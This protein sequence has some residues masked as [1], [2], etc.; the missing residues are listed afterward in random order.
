M[1]EK[2]EGGNNASTENA[3]AKNS[4]GTAKGK[5]SNNEAMKQKAEETN[6]ASKE[7]EEYDLK[8]RLL[9]LAAE[10]DNYKKHAR[11]DIDS[12]KKIG[13]A[14]LVK[15]LLPVLDEFELAIIALNNSTSMQ[16]KDQK[17]STDVSKGIEM[18]YSNFVDALKKNGIHEVSTQGAFDP[19]KHE[20]IMVKESEK[21]DNVII[22]VVKKGYEL[23][24][25]LIRPA[26]VIV[27]KKSDMKK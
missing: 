22:E 10:F 11:S 7:S 25:I 2:E 14:E 16:N 5:D 19:Y 15:S 17:N 23:D 6:R 24:S 20:I 13:K 27:S 18:V 26:S 3:Q 4:E 1:N 21:D 9:R 8:E 12:A